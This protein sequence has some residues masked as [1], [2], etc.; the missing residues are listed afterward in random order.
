MTGTN[1]GRASAS[2]FSV[3]SPPNTVYTIPTMATITTSVITT[4]F[5]MMRPPRSVSNRGVRPPRSWERLHPPHREMQAR[6]PEQRADYRDG[7][8][9]HLLMFGRIGHVDEL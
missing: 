8:A 3:A 2:T 5:F 6:A 1:S 7:G 4:H 9:H